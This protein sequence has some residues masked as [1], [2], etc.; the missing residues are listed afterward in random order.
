MSSNLDIDYL[1][2][3]QDEIYFVNN[4]KPNDYNNS[5]YI[6]GIL[7]CVCVYIYI[8]TYTYTHTFEHICI[9]LYVLLCIYL[10]TFMCTCIYVKETVDIEV[11][12]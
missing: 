9:Y 3:R 6:M 7:I 12:L 10:Y 4:H 8:Y 11:H 5:W 2:G 1:P